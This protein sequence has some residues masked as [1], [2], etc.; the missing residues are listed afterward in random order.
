[1]YQHYPF[2]NPPLPYDYEALEPYIDTKTMQVHHDRHLQTYV[3][4]LNAI[5]KEY[6]TLH[7]LSLT[8]LILYGNRLPLAIRTGVKNNAGGVFNHEFYFEGLTNIPQKEPLGELA[9]AIDKRFG[10]YEEFQKMLKNAAMSVFGSG[11]AWLVMDR[12]GRLKIVTTANQDNP[13]SQ[14]LCPILAL[15]V[16]EHAYYLKHLNKRAEYIENWFQVINW[17]RA[18]AHYI[19]CKE[20]F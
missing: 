19:E 3:D 9:V 18:N 20:I 17:P 13:L 6:P 1:M 10:S 7:S 11:Y 12:G 16:W 5:L 2:E 14:N 4:N 15:D 8:K